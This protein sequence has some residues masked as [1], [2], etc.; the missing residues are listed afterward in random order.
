MCV[1]A[2]EGVAVRAQPKVWMSCRCPPWVHHLICSVEV[3]QGRVSIAHVIA[4]FLRL[5]HAALA[6]GARGGASVRVSSRATLV[7]AC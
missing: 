6:L 7:V 5:G 3:E 1:L 4:A 2:S